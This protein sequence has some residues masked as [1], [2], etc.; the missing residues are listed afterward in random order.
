MIKKIGRVIFSP[1]AGVNGYYAQKQAALIS[2]VSLF[3]AISINSG[4]IYMK[5]YSDNTSVWYVLI[6]AEVGFIISYVL[7]R[8]KL[9][10]AGGTLCVSVLCLIPLFDVYISNN[11]DYSSLMTLLIWNVLT[12]LVSSSFFTMK[13]TMFYSLVN[14][15]TII[16]FPV[17]LDDISLLD[18]S[19]AFIFNIIMPFIIL[20]FSRHKDLIEK[21]R[22]QEILGINAQ[23]EDELQKKSDIQKELI[24]SASHDSLTN[25]PNR[26]ILENRI[27]HA[28]EYMKR[29]ED[30]LFAVIFVD[31]DKFKVVNDT[32]GHQIGDS[33]LIDV[34][35]RLSENIRE[36][37][38]VARLGGDEF[39]ILLEEITHISEVM[40]ILTRLSSSIR[41]PME[42]GGTVFHPSSSLGVYIGKNDTASP[43]DI[44]RYADI[45]MY[46]AKNDPETN[47]AFFD[48]EMLK[49]VEDRMGMEVDLRS[50]LEN[51]DFRVY[52]QPIVDTF[53]KE[54]VG[55]EALLRWAH[56]EKG[57]ISPL[58]FIPI[59]EQTGL[60]VPIGYR[61]LSKV[62]QQIN[63]WKI[64]FPERKSFYI[65]VNLSARQF[66]DK[67]F[68]LKLKTIIE[69][70]QIDP[71]MLR[72]EL[73]ESTIIDSTENVKN[74]LDQIQNM[75]C[76]ILI[77]DFGTG[78]SSL[79][80]LHKLPIDIL[81]VDKSFIDQLSCDKINI[82]NTIISLA[83]NLGM[84]VVAEGI[85]I[86]NQLDLLSSMQCE[87]VQGY[88]FSKPLDPADAELFFQNEHLPCYS[89]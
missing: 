84:K 59:A 60:I 52:Y 74:I 21:N 30:K 50:A 6:T 87:Y 12:I 38:M 34:S 31:L 27:Q 24:Y 8:T 29:H 73:T 35:R 32:F 25:L 18:I 37:D 82:V 11:H 88:L 13:T 64:R 48:Q 26:V 10:K 1:S 77:D 5:D 39:V 57:M 14:L 44:I 23:L 2:Q 53:T 41:T 76:Q 69:S 80:Y 40:R 45:A 86:N 78:Y 19:V 65:S 43:E 9:F 49:V 63:E 89:N 71:S 56:P 20:L 7:S 3:L 47:Y 72:F 55:F 36:Q 17:F 4:V 83:H 85:E 79:S 70:F 68:I 51:D 54:M 66:F 15:L 42:I 28:I 62:C 22:V 46:R 67:G 75:G 33:Y 81:K 58:D 61:V 16:S